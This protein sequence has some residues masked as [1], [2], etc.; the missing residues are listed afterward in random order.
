[1]SKLIMICGKICS[2]KSWYAR[3][4]K[5]RHPAVILST[6]EMT[7]DLI[8]NEQGEKYDA[9][10]VRVNAYLLKK[11]FEIIEAGADVILDWGFW[12]REQR[13]ALTAACREK[14]VTVERHYVEIDDA[15][16]QKNIDERNQRILEDR[17]GSDFYVN[18][19]LRNKLLRLWEAPTSDEIDV[20]H[21]INRN[22]PFC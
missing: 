4:L 2:G 13:E 12:R 7:Y 10:C 5:A 9:F 15:S 6:D 20:W 14:G 3:E 11:A 17:G 16:W 8:D 1:M 18:D 19:G 21:T 22:E